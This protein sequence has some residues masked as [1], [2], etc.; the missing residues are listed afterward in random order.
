MR[1][2]RSRQKH[3][4][5]ND[6]SRG[7]RGNYTRSDYNTAGRRLYADASP[8]VDAGDTTCYA[9]VDRAPGRA[10]ENVRADRPKRDQNR[11]KKQN[12][13]VLRRLRFDDSCSEL[14]DDDDDD[15]D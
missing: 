2:G 7:R 10:A 1:R 3:D 12:D 15:D 6:V 11:D 13:N 8:N 5:A 4:H 9:R 14:D